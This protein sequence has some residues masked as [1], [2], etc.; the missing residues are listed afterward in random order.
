MKKLIVA[1]V[2]LLFM[3]TI[4]LPAQGRPGKMTDEQK[5]EF[6]EKNEDYV[7]KLDLSE[8]QKPKV[9]EI[10]KVFFQ[11]VAELKKSEMSKISKYRKYKDLSSDRDRQMK[12]ILN[13]RQFELYQEH[14]KDMKEEF[15]KNRR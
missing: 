1:G 3:S 7:L 9:K 14:Q 8:E 4:E 15:R 13:K 10:N 12:G 11:G 6:K 5:Q 2:A